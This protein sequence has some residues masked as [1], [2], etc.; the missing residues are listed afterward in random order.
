MVL[1]G[2]P[3]GHARPV[4]RFNVT[5]LVVLLEPD[6]APHDGGQTDQA[7]GLQVGHLVRDEGVVVE[8]L[9]AAY[10]GKV[11]KEMAQGP[12][13]VH[14]VQE[15]VASDFDELWKRILVE[16]ALVRVRYEQDV[17]LAFDNHTVLKLLEVGNLIADINVT[18]NCN[19]EK[20]N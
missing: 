17:K 6:G 14:S 8:Q 3:D 12:Q 15:K 9:L 13:A 11:W 16:V 4:D 10:H 18:T 20:R 2:D 7:Q 19:K 1:N 5:Q